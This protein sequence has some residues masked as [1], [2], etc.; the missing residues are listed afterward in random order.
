MTLYELKEIQTIAMLL[1]NHL[2][3]APVLISFKQLLEWS[4]EFIPEKCS[5]IGLISTPAPPFST[6]RHEYA[7]PQRIC[8]G[9]DCKLQT[10][11]FLMTK[12]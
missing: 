10:Q 7:L 12:N 2:E 8:F 6:L 5:I 4:N 9:K 1:H 11:P 3:V